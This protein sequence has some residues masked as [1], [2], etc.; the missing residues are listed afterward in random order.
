MTQ[1]GQEQRKIYKLAHIKLQQQRRQQREVATY[2]QE[3]DICKLYV[4]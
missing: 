1:K 2:D 3:E 4:W